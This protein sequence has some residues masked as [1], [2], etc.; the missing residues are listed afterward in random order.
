MFE[1]LAYRCAYCNYFNA[2]RKQKPT[3]NPNVLSPSAPVA[4]VQNGATPQVER[5][6]VSTVTDSSDSNE[7]M[8]EFRV[9]RRS[10]RVP[11]KVYPDLSSS[12]ESLSDKKK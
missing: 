11:P 6:E 8:N 12:E 9:T 4:P 3:F 10:I 5:M 2:A 1:F 7:G